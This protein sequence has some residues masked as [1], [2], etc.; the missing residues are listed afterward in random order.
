MNAVKQ[1]NQAGV[2]SIM[3]TMIMMVVISLIV[4]GFAQVARHNQRE[5]LDRHLSSQA[6]YAA[7]AGVNDV[8][9]ALKANRIGLP[10]SSVYNSNCTAFIG[11]SLPAI[12]N[13]DGANT[14]YTCVTINDKPD[15]VVATV[16]LGKS[17]VVP[18]HMDNF[19]SGDLNISWPA[20]KTNGS[21]VRYCPI[22]GSIDDFKPSTIWNWTGSS[23]PFGLLR[24][25]IY[26][27]TGGG[28]TADNMANNSVA[29]YLVPARSSG[30]ERIFFTDPRKSV[31]VNNVQCTNIICTGRLKG[32]QR[33]VA[34]Y[35]LRMSSVYQ[36]VGNVTITGIPRGGSPPTTFSG[37]AIVID[38]TGRAQDQLRRVQ[39]RIPLTDSYGLTIPANSLQSPKAIC[40]RFI[41]SGSGTSAVPDYT[42]PNPLCSL[43]P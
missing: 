29:V 36:N 23:C 34:S 11:S 5:T 21:N 42:A 28:Y 38:S 26:H 40:K 31:Y 43:T 25:D 7:E 39:V 24:L 9:T 13:L 12:N 22:G 18:L 37:G 30:N 41:I 35:Y 6:F 27:D 2:I 1:H 14:S 4:I 8:V 33:G 16:P 17:V 32:L 3:V 20:N 19:N 15:S 10:L